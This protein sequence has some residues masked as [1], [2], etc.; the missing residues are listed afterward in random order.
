M[1][2]PVWYTYDD[3]GKATWYAMPGGT[4]NGTTYTGDLYNPTSSAWLGVPYDAAA[5][6]P[7]KVGSMSL[8]FIDQGSAMM[9]HTI[10][11]VT[12]SGLIIRQPY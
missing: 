12:R 10:N 4:W 7:G 6:K 9:T 1:L 8:T 3:S 11:G 2:F 5:F